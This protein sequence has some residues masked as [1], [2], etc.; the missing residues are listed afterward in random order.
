[1]VRFMCTSVVLACGAYWPTWAQDK[2]AAKK[3]PDGVYAVLRDS[4]NKKDVLPL[5]DGELLLLH[6]HRYLKKADKEPPHYLVVR[7]T[8][9]VDLDLAE[10]PKADKDGAD[11]VRLLLKLKPQAAAALERLTA[12]R[13]GKQ[14]AI[15]IGG[16]VVTMHKIRETIKGGDVQITSCTPGAATFL[17]KQLEARSKK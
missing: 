6:E 13:V 12:D 7:S 10:A 14:V 8:P 2:P 11:V 1:M 16:D 3:A 9:D 15:V 17:L 4:L 5:K